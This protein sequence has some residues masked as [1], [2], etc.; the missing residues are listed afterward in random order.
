MH[1]IPSR[2]CAKNHLKRVPICECA[3]IKKTFPAKV[4]SPIVTFK[5]CDVKVGEL[6]NNEII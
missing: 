3:D 4:I 6:D 5:A 2:L 1:T